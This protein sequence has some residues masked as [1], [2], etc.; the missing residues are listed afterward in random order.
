MS[1]R[2]RPFE[3]IAFALTT[4]FALVCLAVV[5]CQ[6]NPELMTNLAQASTRAGDAYAACPARLPTCALVFPE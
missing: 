2:F 1:P 3:Q 6:R 4:L 5:V